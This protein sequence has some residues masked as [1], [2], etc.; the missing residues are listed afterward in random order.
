M[1]E[2]RMIKKSESRM[3]E[4][5]DLGIQVVIDSSSRLSFVI[6]LYGQAP[7]SQNAPRRTGQTSRSS[8][9]ATRLGRFPTRSVP[10]S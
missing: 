10:L 3:H 5:M 7:Q 1:I 8:S 6:A 2:A 9:P 4:T